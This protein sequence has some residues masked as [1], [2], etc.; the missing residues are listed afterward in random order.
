M[1]DLKL[2]NYQDELDSDEH[3]VD[4]VTHE[5]TDEPSDWT[6][7]P[8]SKLKED[9]DKMAMNEEEDNVDDDTREQIE[10]M[11]EHDQV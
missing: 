4:V 3:E 11:D 8:N 7:V 10:D 2:H 5:E 9:L 1:K 6:G